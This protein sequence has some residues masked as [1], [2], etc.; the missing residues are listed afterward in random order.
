MKTTPARRSSR[1]AASLASTT[2]AASLAALC[3]APAAA[4]DIDSLQLLTQPEFRSLSEDL[5]AALSYKPLIP[6]EAMGITGFDIGVGI[7][8]T[9][10]KHTELLEKAAGATN[11]SGYVAVPTIR[12]HKGLP[13]SIDIGAIYG[14]VPD[15]NIK[16][17]GAEVRWAPLPGS[18]VTPALGIRGSFTRLTG[19]DQLKFQTIG[20]D[21][22]VSKGFA[23][24]T[25]Y[26]GV[27]QVWI[28]S[29]PNLPAPF[30]QTL[31]EEKFTQTKVFVGVNI[32][33]GLNIAI[34]VDNTGGATSA[35][36]KLSFGF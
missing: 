30:T 27:G 32:N 9:K 13:A 2:L 1:R 18:T 12:A 24:I 36:V 8:A 5:G 31:I 33:L 7:T 20:L 19:V 29:T 35:G 15:S 17:Y 10:L 28:K 23:N 14:Q 3:A 26:G 34:E 6:A 22:A 21:V 25:P 16:L 4:A 11:M